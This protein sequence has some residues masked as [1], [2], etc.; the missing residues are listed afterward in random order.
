M[1]KAILLVLLLS[2]CQHAVFA[3]QQTDWGAFN[4]TINVKPY[5]GKNFRL[6]AA[7]KVQ[8]IDSSAEAEI[9]VRVDRPNKKIG[10]FYNMM[11]KPIR[12]AEWKVYSITGKIDKDAERLAFG[13]LYHRRANFY[14][15]E[16][17]LLV[18]SEKDKW[19]EIP[20]NQNGF[21]GDSAAIAQSW[22]YLRK[23]MNIRATKDNVYAGGQSLLVDGSRF[24]Y[25]KAFGNNIDSGA[26]AN[27]NNIRLYYEVYGSG[28]PLLLLHGNSSSIAS[29]EKQIPE[30]AKSY[31]VIALDSRGQGKSTEDGKTFTYE[32]FA[33]DT[34]ALLD[35]LQLDSVNVLGW[36]DGGNTGLILAM[37]YPAKVKRLAIMGANLYNNASSVKPWVNKLLKKELAGIK[38]TLRNSVF[39]KRM[40]TLLLTQPAIDPAELQNITCPVLVMAGSDDVIKEEH[41]RL[42]AATIKRSQL[43]IFPKG[44]HEEPAKRPE[45]FNKA[46]VDFL[47]TASPRGLQ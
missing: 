10:F 7:V 25:P 2:A 46:V 12:S 34:R 11:D 24:T 4:Q 27:V 22:G 14:Y 17:R 19:E 35:H 13:G 1:R 26:Y 43:I 47:A 38:D 18:E 8:L 3:Q 33:E 28:E 45:R 31:K 37:K 32:L 36:S 9:W 6:E 44:D 5:Q 23:G 21:E 16:F 41:T 20:V 15:D 30:L 29:F 39:R 40:I 42:I